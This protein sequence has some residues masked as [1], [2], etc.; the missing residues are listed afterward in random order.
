MWPPLLTEGNVVRQA[1]VQY[2]RGL[3][4]LLLLVT[5]GDSAVSV[6]GL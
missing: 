1:V 3:M 2:C 4:L 6:V 5:V